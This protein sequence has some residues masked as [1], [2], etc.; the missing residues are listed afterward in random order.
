VSDSEFDR[1]FRRVYQHYLSP[2]AHAV[3]PDGAALLG[4][5]S[6][7]R[8]SFLK[9]EVRRETGHTHTHDKNKG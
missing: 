2:A 9:E 7:P 5:A 3:L 4:W 6:S 1:F 8:R